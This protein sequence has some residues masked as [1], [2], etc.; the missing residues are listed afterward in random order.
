[1]VLAVKKLEAS[2]NYKKILKNIDLTAKTGEFIGIVGP[3]GAGKST[4]M[5]CLRGFMPIQSGDVLLDGQSIHSLDD[6]EIARKIAYLQQEINVSFGFTALEVVLTGRYPYLKWWQ[7]ENHEDY[8]IARQYMDFTGVKELENISVQNMSGGQR[9]RVL[10]AKVLA[11]Q[12]PFIFLDEPTANLDLVY[13]EE[14]FRYCQ[15]VCQQ[16]KTVLIIA[17]D[18]KLAAKFCSR[19][20]L[21]SDGMII[22]DGVPEK[23]VTVKNL[24]N[25][26]GLHAAVFTNKVTGNLDIH[27]FS[28]KA[29][30]SAKPL[31][32]V[33]GGGGAGG[34]IIRFLFEKGYPV[35]SG[36]YQ[37]G[38]TDIDVASAFGVDS[39]IAEPFCCIDT[40]SG[41]KN[42]E[43]IRQAEWT[44]LANLYYGEQNLDNLRA[45]FFASQLIVIED[46]C[47]EDR[48]YTDGKAIALYKE[49]LQKDYVSVLTASEFMNQFE[50]MK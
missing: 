6:K 19:L 42:R 10:L 12:T 49:L 26:Y 43:K 5:R 4:L 40:L 20:I 35:S 3:N 36:V 23:V 34:D 44:I 16:G 41:K 28:H 8:A 33:I 7:K 14:I 29:V 47:I 13:Q 27:T 31:V 11:Q 32:H 37:Y 22:A 45:A 9:Q 24:Q 21:L 38:D 39:I 46:D 1:M 50:H 48:D 25:A 15:I 18:L 2:L 30:S 17:H